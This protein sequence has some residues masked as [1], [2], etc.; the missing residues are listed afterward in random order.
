MASHSRR[1]RQMG[2][3]LETL[4]DNVTFKVV[5]NNKNFTVFG[6]TGEQI[7]AGSSPVPSTLPLSQLWSV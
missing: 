5:L 7:S 1:G 2:P 6:N 4:L 3:R